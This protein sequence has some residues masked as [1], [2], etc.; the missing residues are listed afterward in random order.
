VIAAYTLTAVATVVLAGGLPAPGPQLLIS[1]GLWVLLQVV[2]Y[3]VLGLGIA[4]LL[5]TR[6]YAIGITLAWRLALTPLLMSIP[7]FEL[8]RELV[9][10]SALQHLAPAALG[11]TVRQGGVVPMSTAAAVAVLAV[12]SVAAV[13]AGAWRDATR[14]A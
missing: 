8:G 3:Y 1:T 9:P 10:G 12:W 5:G 11:D 6:S 13:A 7:S 4:C 14:E 2:F